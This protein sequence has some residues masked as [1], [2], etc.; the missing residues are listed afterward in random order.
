MLKKALDLDPGNGDAHA[1]TALY[2]S[3]IGDYTSL[4][5]HVHL[6]QDKQ[7]VVSPELLADLKRKLPEPTR[8]RA[9]TAQP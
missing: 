8:Q 3:T 2:Y 6:A 4:W 7:A 9:V 5:R 1:N